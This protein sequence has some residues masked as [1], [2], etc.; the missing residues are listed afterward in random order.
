MHRFPRLGGF[1][2]FR[3]PFWG[4]HNKGFSILG[5][6]LGYPHFGKLPLVAPLFFMSTLPVDPPCSGQLMAM[7]QTGRL[8]VWSEG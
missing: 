3:V 4:H 7:L 5:S 6:M 2:K 1:P 8:A